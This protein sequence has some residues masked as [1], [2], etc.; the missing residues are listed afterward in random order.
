MKK[1]ISVAIIL[2]FASIL[3]ADTDP[4]IRKAEKDVGD[5]WRK[6]G[7][8]ISNTWKKAGKD[9]KNNNKSIPPNEQETKQ[10]TDKEIQDKK[11]EER[12]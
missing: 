2:S 12:K 8:D 5:T 10:A 3:F 6:A 4:N 1:A 9:I 7:K 11:D